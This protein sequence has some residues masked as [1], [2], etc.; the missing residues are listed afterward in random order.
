[1]WEMGDVGRVSRAASP[2]SRFKRIQ[3]RHLSI[4]W[5]R[6]IKVASALD[7][8]KGSVFMKKEYRIGS[9]RDCGY[10]AQP[11]RMRR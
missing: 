7:A 1:M 5:R 8:E 9:Y 2:P 3:S 6:Q 10:G 11:G 4:E